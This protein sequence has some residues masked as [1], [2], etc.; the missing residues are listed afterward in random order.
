MLGMQ[1]SLAPHTEGSPVQYVTILGPS[2]VGS[3][4]V[5]MI[6]FGPPTIAQQIWPFG[7][8][9]G[10][11]Q[12][13]SDSSPWQLPG[14]LQVSLLGPWPPWQQTCPASQGDPSQLSTGGP[15]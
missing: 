6:P 3:Q 9:A 15:P 8:L 2:Q 1:V 14:V 13:I 7:Q 4:V 10:P 11:E 5:P 12:V